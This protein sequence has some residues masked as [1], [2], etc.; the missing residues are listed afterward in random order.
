MSIPSFHS[1][2]KAITKMSPMQYIKSTRLHQARL[3]MVRNELTAEAAAHA[4]G[5]ASPSQF[6]R[7][8]RRL[9]GLTPAAEAKRMR[10]SF[11][12]PAAFAD[13][14]YVSSH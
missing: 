6:S 3:L 8:F 12:M 9:F 5:Y 13:A 1:H 7:E 4:V 10:E 11:A 14:A 2:F